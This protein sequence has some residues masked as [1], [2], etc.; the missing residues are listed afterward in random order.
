M[1]MKHFVDRY[2]IYFAY[3]PSKIKQ[4]IHGTA[5]N[6]VIVSVVLLQASFMLLSIV[7]NHFQK[8]TIYAIIGFFITIAFA[9]A[10]CFLRWCESWGPIHYQ[11]CLLRLRL[12]VSY[13]FL[14][15][16]NF[17][18]VLL[19]KQSAKSR[20]AQS[21]RKRDVYSQ[22]Q[23]VPDVLR[24]S[25]LPSHREDNNGISQNNLVTLYTSP[26]AIETQIDN[27][28]AVA[29]LNEKD[30]TMLYQ[31]YNGGSIQTWRQRSRNSC[32][33][34]VLRTLAAPPSGILF[35]WVFENVPMWLVFVWYDSNCYRPLFSSSRLSRFFKTVSLVPEYIGT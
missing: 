32:T 35:F 19:Q 4:Q 8:I 13:R 17:H 24:R 12:I 15:Y 16:L 7:R 14:L 10:Q 21:P 18:V 3:G 28:S 6:F 26:E 1:L 30:T 33:F 25:T 22:C 11:V 9:F 29:S 23:Y 20:A 31:N 2:N 34:I 27:N 5:I